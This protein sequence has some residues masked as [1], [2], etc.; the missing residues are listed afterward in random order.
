MRLDDLADLLGA[1]DPEQLLGWWREYQADEG[2][3]GERFLGWLHE[4]DRIATRA[5][6]EALTTGPL[7]VD[8]SR[9]TLY[10]EARGSLRSARTVPPEQRYRFL[11]AVGAGGM[12]EVL[13]AAD[14]ALQ[15]KV[16]FKRM[17]PDAM[18]SVDAVARFFQEA[19]VT[20]QLD[21]PNVVPIYSLETS[22]SS[23]VPAYTM[24]LVHGTTLAELVQ[25]A[26][27]HHDLPTLLDHFLKVCEALAYAHSRGVLHRD[28]KPDNI[29]VGAWGEVYVMDWGIARLVDEGPPEGEDPEEGQAIGTPAYMSPEQAI[30]H[31]FRLDA[32]SD[33]YSLGLI[34]FELATLQ[35][36]VPGEGFSVVF[37][38]Q[39]GEKRQPVNAASG[40]PISK[41]LQAIIDKATAFEPHRRYPDVS[42]L[43]EDVRR[44]M[45]GEPTLARPDNLPR[46]TR[47]WLSLHLGKVLT[48]GLLALLGAAA[49][50]IGALVFLQAGLYG[51]KVREARL[52]EAIMEVQDRASLGDAYF[53]ELQGFLEGLSASA[54][55]AL[56][57]GASGDD[58]LYFNAD[59]ESLDTSPP[60]TTRAPRY[61]TPVSFGWPV[62]KLAP[63]TERAEVEADLQRLVR[64]RHAFA[65]TFLRSHAEEAAA[66]GEAEV[67]Q[68]LGHRGVPIIWS[69]V[70]L[71][72]GVHT[73]FPGHGGYPEAY[74]PRQRPWYRLALEHRGPV[75]GS[76]YIDVNGLGLILPCVQTLRDS[77][78]HILGVAGVE[79]SFDTI[80]HR[81]LDYDELRGARE[82]SLVDQEGRVVIHS[83]D[84]G[85]EAEA[86]LHGN[87]ALDL[88]AYELPEVVRAIGA[89]ESGF[90]EHAGDLVLF[91]RMQSLGWTLVVEGDA[92]EMLAVF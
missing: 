26:R 77:E 13:V 9:S 31:N 55:H 37:R 91:Q 16:A 59:F 58:P 36:A 38:A 12:G 25:Q 39:A 79:V 56:Q 74:D 52:T 50:T 5:F 18:G 78:D 67:V 15:R 35:R 17:L 80:I 19:Q 48:L 42:A 23:E 81:L 43:A 40:Q 21:H 3:D 90:V 89:G 2:G 24:K 44:F 28:L 47:R 11:G 53:L 41:D 20:A 69:Y 1:D 49:I 7:Q 72:Q 88:Q 70:A 65:R 51:A 87:Q 63:G 84:L 27:E 71:Q 14:E 29:M 8:A 61:K 85:A 10:T 66:L 46:R 34:L 86:G 57:S 76:P 75:W 54:V 32:R 83:D 92:D 6:T 82:A 33:Q 68:L 60:D 62:F 30:G 73:S 22:S 4:R 64:M 45:R